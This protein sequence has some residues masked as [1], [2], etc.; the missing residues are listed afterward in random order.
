MILSGKTIAV[1]FADGRR[2]EMTISN[3]DELRFE[4]RE[5]VSLSKVLNEGEGVPLW[6]VAGIVHWRLLRSAV[7]N[8]P[9]D[10]D[11]FVDLLDPDNWLEVLGEGKA[12]ASGPAPVTGTSP[13]S[14]GDSASPPET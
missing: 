7:E 8:I 2:E 5:K 4:Q 14:A 9:A 1:T 6:V 13:P 12:E 11:E 10:F 3:S